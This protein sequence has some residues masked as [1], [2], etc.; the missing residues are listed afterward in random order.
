MR[1][2]N[3]GARTPGARREDSCTR[4][5]EKVAEIKPLDTK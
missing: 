2:E 1:D 4:L 3:E 5:V